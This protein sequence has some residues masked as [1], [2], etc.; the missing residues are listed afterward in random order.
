M[1]LVTLLLMRT[2]LEYS[3]LKIFDGKATF[4]T[5]HTRTLRAY[6]FALPAKEAGADFRLV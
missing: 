2:R 1:A 6:I 5:I 3:S 4:A